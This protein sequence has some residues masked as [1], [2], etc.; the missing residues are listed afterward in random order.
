MKFVYYEEV[1]LEQHKDLAEEVERIAMCDELR[2]YRAWF[3]PH[4]DFDGWFI[5][6]SMNYLNEDTDP[7]SREPDAYGLAKTS[8]D[9]IMFRWSREGDTVTINSVAHKVILDL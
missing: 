2:T 5:Q 9:D 3:G 1:P 4:P 8:D 7:D 6:W